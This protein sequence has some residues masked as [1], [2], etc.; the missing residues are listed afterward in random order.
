MK[1]IKN[2]VFAICGILLFLTACKDDDDFTSNSSYKVS[3]SADT[4]SFDTIF[5]DMLTATKRIMVYN[6][7]NENI[8][9]DRIYLKTDYNCFQVNVNGRSG[10]EWHDVELRSDDSMYVF[11]QAKLSETG[12]NT[13]VFVSSD[14]VFEYNG[15]TQSVALTTFGQDTH[16]RRKYKVSSDEHWSNDKP[17]LIYD[18]LE[19]CP[20]ATLKIDEGTTLYFY[21]DAVMMVNGT[22][23]M[24]GTTGNKILLR[25]H[26]SDCIYGE[27]SY[28]KIVGQW[29]GII[30][31][32]ESY[33]NVLNHTEIRSSSFGIKADTA[34]SCNERK[35]TL[36]N[37]VIHNVKGIGLQLLNTNAY[38]YNSVISNCLNGCVMLAGGNY[39]FNHCTIA[40]FPHNSRFH[41]A[42]VLSSSAEDNGEKLPLKRSEFNN[43]IVYGSYVKELTLDEDYDEET[44]NYLFNTCMIRYE[45]SDFSFYENERFKNVYWNQDT[46]FKLINHIDFEYD[47][48]LDSLSAA[49]D[50]ADPTIVE[51]Y[52]ECKH[53]ILGKARPYG[54]GT[55]IGAFEW[56][57][58][59]DTGKDKKAEE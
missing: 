33:G 56:I 55:D 13:P 54:D 26:R 6:T 59:V 17:Y 24:N 25:G 47:F 35:L 38:V 45:E 40:N 22:I 12:K 15:N 23:E 18:T 49:I 27:T 43:C 4:I 41:N 57:P 29:G 44:F 46:Y 21:T 58:D 2:I 20:G 10:A 19:V 53:D 7:T 11:V 1:H 51:S 31:G 50:V 36:A 32:K 9:I 39:V 8:R 48:S 52:P 42:L 37:S 28:D 34:E 3:F 5:T 30:I 16:R 14:L